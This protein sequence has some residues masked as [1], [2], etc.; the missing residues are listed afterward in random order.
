MVCGGKS[1][2]AGIL[3]ALAGR[4]GSSQHGTGFPMAK[5]R[6]PRVCREHHRPDR[7][8]MAMA[9]PGSERCTRHHLEDLHAATGS[10]PPPPVVRMR[11]S[12]G[13]R[14]V[15]Y[16]L[17]Q[18]PHVRAAIADLKA[19][20]LNRAHQRAEDEEQAAALAREA[21]LDR[22]ARLELTARLEIE[23]AERRQ[24]ILMRLH[25]EAG[26]RHRVGSQ[27]GA[28][29]RFARVCRQYRGEPAH[30]EPGRCCCGQLATSPRGASC[31]YCR[32]RNRHYR[33]RYRAKVRRA[34]SR[35][36]AHLPAH[37]SRGRGMPRFR[38]VDSEPSHGL[39]EAAVRWATLRE[40]RLGQHTGSAEG[41]ADA[42]LVHRDQLGGPVEVDDLLRREAGEYAAPQAQ[43]PHG[44]RCGRQDCCD[45]DEGPEKR[46]DHALTQFFIRH[47]LTPF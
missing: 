33:R 17:L 4:Q 43:D 8:C 42:A 19:A 20:I 15:G 9:A 23:E 38:C 7:K 45:R 5:Q 25:H 46:Q 27:G 44:A 37:R 22:L 26:G 34:S 24:R 1:A 47:A 16:C 28:Q 12:L 39:G 29:S 36:G 14:R 21:E 32:E 41:Q 18:K 30:R 6:R 40:M 13:A 11:R 2:A 10:Q 31:D 35:L 3:L